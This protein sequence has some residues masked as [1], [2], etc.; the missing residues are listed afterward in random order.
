[1]SDDDF[2]SSLSDENI[3]NNQDMV[4]LER[5][6]LS[7][8]SNQMKQNVPLDE[9]LFQVLPNI[10]TFTSYEAY[11]TYKTVIKLRNK[12]KSARKTT[13]IRSARDSVIFMAPKMIALTGNEAEKEKLK[14]AA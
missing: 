14:P 11:H 8:Y 5:Y 3:E 6:N 7:D 1:M 12:D 9:P 13:G 4:I 10:P 2:N